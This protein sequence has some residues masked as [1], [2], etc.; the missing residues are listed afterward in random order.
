MQEVLCE[1]DGWTQVRAP[2]SVAVHRGA[3]ASELVPPTTR[4]RWHVAVRRGT[5]TAVTVEM[6]R[7]SQCPVL[8]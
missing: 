4:C 2:F 3:A 7:M 8:K 5:A 1:G 6:L